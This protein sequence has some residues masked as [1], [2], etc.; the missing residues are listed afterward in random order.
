MMLKENLLMLRNMHGFSQEEIAER[1]GISRQAYAKWESGATVPDIEKCSLLAKVYGTTLDSLVRTETVEGL[2]VIP[3]API[4]KSIWGSVTISDR[5]QI[6]IPKG[7]RDLFDLTGGQRL[8]VA[9][10]ER[11]IALIPAKT[12]EEIIKNAMEHMSIKLDE[13]D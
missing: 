13:A 9:S 4:G 2:G 10:D 11:G 6:V 5:G 1:I 12:F 8:I 7:A 3:P